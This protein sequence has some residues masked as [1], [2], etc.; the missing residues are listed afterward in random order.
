MN[1]KIFFIYLALLS[2]LYVSA[3]RYD[4]YI[5][6]GHDN[7]IKVLS[8]SSKSIVSL[9]Y[10][11]KG[12]STINGSGLDYKL[13]EASRFLTQST[14]GPD[15]N[16]IEEVADMGI[17]NWLDDQLNKPATNFLNSLYD[18]FNAINQWRL[19][20]GVD[21]TD[22]ADSPSWTNFLY[23]WWENNIFNDDMV[24]QR[25]A[26]ALSEI[27]VVSLESDLSSFPEALA[28][29]YDIF[30]EGAFGNFR[31]IMDRVTYHMAMGYYLS[32]LN[33][34]KTIPSENIHPDENYAR[35]IMQLFTIGLY[36]LNNDGTRKHDADGNDI[37]TYTNDDIKELAKVFTG[38]G[39]GAI[40]PN[41]WV[42][43]PNFSYS[44]WISDM[45]VPM[46]MYNDWHEQGEKVLL[47]GYVISDGN[48]GDTD[49]KLALDYL[50]NHP[51]TG[52]FICKQLIQKLVKSNPSSE[53][54]DR[55]ASVFNSNE[56]GIRGDMKSVI[57]AI[58]MDEEARDCHWMED[59][60]NGKLRE[61]LLRYLAFTRATD[62]DQAFGNYWNIGWS[63][64]QETGQAPM[65]SPSVFNFY[66]PYFQPN[67]AIA[68]EGLI[69]PEF[70]I[71]NSRTSVGYMNNVYRWARWQILFEDWVE[72]S[73]NAT[74]DFYRLEPMS[75]D[76]EVL[77]NYFDI[78]Y[79][80]GTLS[81]ETR[82]I[83][84]ETV[85]ELSGSDYKYNRA[86]LASYLML[87]SPDFNII[88]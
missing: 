37:P 38:L 58:F 48:D 54:V 65:A 42:T 14:F 71:H 79:T 70:Q 82:D 7:N 26:F 83:I 10:Q 53:Y 44:I 61:P 13:M 68:D 33:N 45:T 81:D 9:D 66:L 5:G 17:E 74:V 84:K 64:W 60:T 15:M 55:V 8:S 59:S 57:K 2:S 3:Q 51:N 19:T 40:L 21:S 69:A 80:Y 27:L 24:R 41:Q 20:H 29:Y 75:R 28:S 16:T 31:D 30:S 23:T 46:K 4:D 6:A 1:R 78:I 36:E 73:P 22:I 25:V 67:G 43:E 11:A 50:F 88:K 86:T 87:I 77:L 18:N 56:S 34:P 76:P 12:E 49:I 63:F 39:P 52:P 62:K 35:E 85:S 72:E 47:N 32:H